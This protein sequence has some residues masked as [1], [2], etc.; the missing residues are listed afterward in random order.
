MRIG[1][2]LVVE[3]DEDGRVIVSRSGGETLGA[4]RGGALD[5]AAGALP[6]VW[7]AGALDE[8]RDEWRSPLSTR[9]PPT[10]AHR[11]SSAAE[12]LVHPVRASK[13]REVMRAEWM[14]PRG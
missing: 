11:G 8:V 1:E 12:V 5:R 13:E 2:E 14:E 3:A 6:G 10:L 7:S 4:R 9:T